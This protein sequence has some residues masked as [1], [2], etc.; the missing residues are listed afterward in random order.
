LLP[1]PRIAAEPAPS[2]SGSGATS[3][4]P[5]SLS[6]SWLRPYAYGQLRIIAGLPVCHA[7]SD[8]GSM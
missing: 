7:V 4:L 1:P 8:S 5:L 6:V 3:N 2:N